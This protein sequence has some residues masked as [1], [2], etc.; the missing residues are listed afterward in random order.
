MRARCPYAH[1][2]LSTLP[3]SGFPWREDSQKLYP[4]RVQY[5]IFSDA[6]PL[7]APVANMAEQVRNNRKPV[8][9]D[10]PFLAVQ[11]NMSTQ[12]VAALDGWR[13]FIETVAE[14][15]FLTLY[16]SPAVQAAAGIDPSDT[17]PLRKPASNQLYHE[18][19]QNRVAELRS[20]ITAGGRREAV[21]RAA[22]YVGLGR[23]AVDER[24]FESVRRLR[25]RYGDMRLSE[26]KALVRD[27]F[28]ILLIDRQGA[29]AALPSLLPADAETRS[30]AFNLVRQVM[31]ACGE[32]SA[33]DEKRLSE[34]GRLF[35]IA[36]EGGAI[37]FPQNR[38]QLPAKAS[39]E[40]TSPAKPASVEK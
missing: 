16:G 33:E 27:Q 29:L 31:A 3:L 25:G 22:L 17:R 4:L 36:E 23:T 21:I 15:T 32:L 6:N 38:R 7:M 18:L 20:H 5:E 19:L 30:K 34:I 39:E 35:G 24:G 2:E 8:A 11:E 40:R 28:A 14:R 13:D 12:I 37:P 26:F 1:G 9:A 10:N